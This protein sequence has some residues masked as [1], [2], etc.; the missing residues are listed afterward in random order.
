MYIYTYNWLILF[1]CY[2]IIGQE[3][4]VILITLP[5]TGQLYNAGTKNSK[6]QDIACIHK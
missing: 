6:K 2:C 4:N 5:K 3:Y 1:I